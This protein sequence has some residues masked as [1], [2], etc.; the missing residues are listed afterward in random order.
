MLQSIVRKSK[1]SGQKCRSSNYRSTALQKVRLQSHLGKARRKPKNSV[2][3]DIL[4]CRIIGVDAIP[5][6]CCDLYDA[7]PS[8]DLWKAVMLTWL[9]Q[10]QSKCAG[11]FNHYYLKC[12]LDRVFAVRK[13]DHGT[14]GWWPTECPA[15]LDWYKLLYPDR[16]L[17]SEE[18]FQVLCETYATLNKMQKL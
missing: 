18:K 12:S 4:A 15:Y 1:V 7:N 10:V 16:S 3:R 13:I 17:S 11:C 5:G 8:R 9:E 14:I 2:A 6:T